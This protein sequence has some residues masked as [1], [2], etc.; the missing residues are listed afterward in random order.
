MT[1]AS[2]FEAGYAPGR[3]SPREGASI[4]WTRTA[5]QAIVAAA[6]IAVLYWHVLLTL[7][8]KWQTIGD[9][10]HGFLI[11]VF[12]V[13]YLYL[14]RHRFPT[15]PA[16]TGY[17]GLAVMLAAF[18]MYWYYTQ[19]AI[20]YYQSLSLVLMIFGVTYLLCGWPVTRWAWFAIAFLVFALPIPG[21]VYEQMTIPLQKIASALA[22]RILNAV[23]NMEAEANNIVISY[24]YQG[25]EGELN[26]EQACSGIR[27]MMAFVALGVAMA[28]GSERRL[29][30]RMVMILS[31][32]PIAIFCNVVRVTTTGF[33]VVF[34]HED[35]AKG[36]YHML[37]GLSMLLIAF[38]LFG[39]I[40]YVLGHLF[41][42]EP[43]AGLPSR[44]A[45][46]RA[47]QE[48]EI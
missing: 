6:L 30:H 24:L 2:Q 17:A 37:L 34:G 43:E 3:R 41:V 7:V 32:V 9:W 19:T 28:F 22:A 47:G 21:G 8:V 5:F 31:C 35:W 15:V 45:V 16:R 12:S 46:P 26:V 40:S 25:R 39:L 38:G 11:P 27:L 44:Q 14:Q 1:S 13:Y 4:D 48:S 18:V 36:S 29:W 23:P 20:A 10:S 33:F 42:E